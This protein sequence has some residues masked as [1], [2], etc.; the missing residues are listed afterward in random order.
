MPH[1]DRRAASA[2]GGRSGKLNRRSVRLVRSSFV[3]DDGGFG[4]GGDGLLLPAAD[5]VREID[6]ACPALEAL[7]RFPVGLLPGLVSQARPASLRLDRGH[8]TVV[9][10]PLRPFGR[11]RGSPLHLCQSPTRVALLPCRSRGR[12][13]RWEGLGRRLFRLSMQIYVRTRLRSAAGQRCNSDTL[14]G[15]SFGPC[16]GERSVGS[17]DGKRKV[18]VSQHANGL[19]TQDELT[20]CLLH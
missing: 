17:S 20:G 11:R 14:G 12:R 4:F 18:D 9:E 13:S 15:A 3:H 19:V 10:H 1:G 16:V 6:R 2:R 5:G 8:A 7:E